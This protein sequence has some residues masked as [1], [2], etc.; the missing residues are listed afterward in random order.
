MWQAP[1]CH[2][3]NDMYVSSINHSEKHMNSM[4]KVSARAAQRVYGCVFYT[5][6]K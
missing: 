2:A 3:D 1:I 4:M 5:V 6:R